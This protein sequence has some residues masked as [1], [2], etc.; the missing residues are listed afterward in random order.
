MLYRLTNLIDSLRA[1]HD[2]GVLADRMPAGP[3][4]HI[5]SGIMQAKVIVNSFCFYKFS[6][7]KKKIGKFVY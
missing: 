2:P 4:A 1:N 7:K 3:T 6:K 5:H